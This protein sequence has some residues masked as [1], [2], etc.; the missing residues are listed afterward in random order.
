MAK[1]FQDY[2]GEPDDM[3][4]RIQQLVEVQQTREQLLDKAQDHQ[5]KIKQAFDKKV[6]KEDF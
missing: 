3:V 6:S 2:Q 5:Q 1:F 4:R